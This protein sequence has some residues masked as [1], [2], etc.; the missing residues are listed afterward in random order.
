MCFLNS[1][2]GSSMGE[3]RCCYSLDDPSELVVV[4]FAQMDLNDIGAHSFDARRH[5]VVVHH[6]VA[7]C[8]RPQARSHGLRRWGTLLSLPPSLQLHSLVWNRSLELPSLVCLHL[9]ARHPICMWWSDISLYLV[10]SLEF[11]TKYLPTVYKKASI[12]QKNDPLGREKEHPYV[13]D[14]IWVLAFL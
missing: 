3:K 5:D 9:C 8:F 4:V 10:L 11:L 14:F 2:V 1:S 13:Y 6:V 12:D 7:P